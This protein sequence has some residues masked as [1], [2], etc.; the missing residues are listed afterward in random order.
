MSSPGDSDRRSGVER[1]AQRGEGTRLRSGMIEEQLN[2]RGHK[3]RNGGAV[4]DLHTLR[5]G[6]CNLTLTFLMVRPY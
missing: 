1:A 2:R 3:A 4:G 6:C 5:R